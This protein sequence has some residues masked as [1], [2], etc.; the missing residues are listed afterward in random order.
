LLQS[1]FKEI[2]MNARSITHAVALIAVAVSGVASASLDIP[3]LVRGP[4]SPNV[5][6]AMVPAKVAVCPAPYTAVFQNNRLSCER[7]I[8]QTAAIQCP[9][10]FP[11][12]VARNA[13][14]AGNAD[15]DLCA[16][17]GVNIPSTGP[18][19][20]LTSGTDFV[21][22]P[23]DGTLGPVSYVAGHPSVTEVNS[24]GWR[25]DVSNTGSSGIS[26]RYRR[27]FKVKTSPILVNP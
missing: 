4:L 17:A 7:T 12:Y 22:V 13:T 20:G 26:D 15:R 21:R 14:G 19:T 8:T 5:R 2:I 25:L 16:K 1:T 23:V 10:N 18:L 24:E 11:N 3:D 6:A 27:T 9:S